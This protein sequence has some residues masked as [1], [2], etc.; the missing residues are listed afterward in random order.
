MSRR[1]STRSTPSSGSAAA[2]RTALLG[3]CAG[4]IIASITAAYLA[5][6]GERDRLAAFGL[7]VTVLDNARA[8]RAGALVDERLAAAAKAASRRRGLPGRPEPRRGVRL[9]AARAT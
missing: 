3:V 9:A 2:D 7:L 5:G 6:T 4:G 8:G 1:C